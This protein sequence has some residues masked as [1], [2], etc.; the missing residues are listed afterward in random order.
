MARYGRVVR[1][2]RL[3]LCAL[4]LAAGR[5]RQRLSRADA[6]RVRRRGARQMANPAA[7][8]ALCVGWHGV[9]LLRREEQNVVAR[10]YTVNKTRAA[11][12]PP[13]HGG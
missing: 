4:I 13:T 9:R 6:R 5:R 10:Y 8:L 7:S 11:S 12:R 1:S 2:R 3:V